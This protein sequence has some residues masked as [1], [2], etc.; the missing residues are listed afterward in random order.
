MGRSR[1]A[2]WSSATQADEEAA[3]WERRHPAGLWPCP[4]GGSSPA[5]CRR[6]QP[7]R[8]SS[9]V[10]SHY[11]SAPGLRRNA[12]ARLRLAGGT[13]HIPCGLNESAPSSRRRLL[14]QVFWFAVLHFVILKIVTGILFFFDHLPPKAVNL[15]AV[16]EFLSLI[17]QVLVFPRWL[18]LKLWP[19]ET[20]PAGL[21]LAL[22]IFNSA[23]WG[24]ALAGLRNFW[25]K[26]TA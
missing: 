18:V 17:N 14:K 12:P 22:T 6:S 23:V 13:V 7:I 3:R 5:G 16:I 8:V 9:G 4:V 2:H 11:S 26:V 24:M 15:S 21:G 20:T 25:R 10:S 19:W 1:R